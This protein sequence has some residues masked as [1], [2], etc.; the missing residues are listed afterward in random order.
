MSEVSE[1]ELAALNPVVQRVETQYRDEHKLW[2][3]RIRFIPAGYARGTAEGLPGGAKVPFEILQRLFY[4]PVY[5]LGFDRMK[6]DAWYE[7]VRCPG[8]GVVED[9]IR[10]SVDHIKPIAKGGLELDRT[11]LR[12]LCL[13]CNLRRGTR[14][15]RTERA[16]GG[17]RSLLAFA[18]EGSPTSKG[19]P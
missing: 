4:W 11:N 7:K 12:F 6:R 17:Q 13:R 3:R 8:D 10:M 1:A 9:A 15:L 16:T 19:A 2:G 5:P 18:T 14:P